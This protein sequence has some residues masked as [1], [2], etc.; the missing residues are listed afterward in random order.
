MVYSGSVAKTPPAARRLQPCSSNQVAGRV[1]REWGRGENAFLSPHVN[2]SSTG[3]AMFV[4]RWL[5]ESSPSGRLADGL[6]FI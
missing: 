6:T 5:M 3:I 1:E 2:A 4:I